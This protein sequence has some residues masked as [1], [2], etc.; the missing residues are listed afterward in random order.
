MNSALPQQINK[1]ETGLAT[2]Q[3]DR[4]TQDILGKRRSVAM[5]LQSQLEKF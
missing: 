4:L 2:Q 3:M 1:V 5:L